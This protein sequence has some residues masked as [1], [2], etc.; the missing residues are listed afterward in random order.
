LWYS[1]G[2]ALIRWIFGK[3]RKEKGDGS[4]RREGKSRRHAREWNWIDK[5]KD[6]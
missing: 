2:V 6:W 4:E 5:D 3:K 1:G